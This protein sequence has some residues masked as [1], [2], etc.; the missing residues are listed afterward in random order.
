LLKLAAWNGADLFTPLFLTQPDVIISK[1]A[2]FENTLKKGRRVRQKITVRNFPTT[3]KEMKSFFT[4][5]QP[6]KA[7]RAFYSMLPAWKDNSILNISQ[8]SLDQATL[9]GELKKLNDVL[10][11]G[12]LG[13]EDWGW[14][15]SIQDAVISDISPDGTAISGGA[16]NY[17]QGKTGGWL[18]RIPRE[19][20][21]AI[22]DNK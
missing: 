17:T 7:V 16:Y 15:L 8:K 14:G 10:R 18:A 2:Q 3:L 6:I 19:S 21:D 20:S 12:G 5:G 11:D 22:S 1:V 9:G 4:Q 13:L